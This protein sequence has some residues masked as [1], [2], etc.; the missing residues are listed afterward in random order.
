MAETGVAN[1]LCVYC[2]TRL[3]PTRIQPALICVCVNSIEL[4]NGA[5][6]SSRGEIPA[7]FEGENGLVT[8]VDGSMGPG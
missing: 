5:R 7:T 8:S 2:T 1:F 3:S 4:R 6:L